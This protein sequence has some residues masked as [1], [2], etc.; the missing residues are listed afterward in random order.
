MI[1]FIYPFGRRFRELAPN[2]HTLG[3]VIHAR[4]G[5]SS[6]L[7]LAFSNLL[8]SIISLMVNLLRQGRWYRYCR[9]CRSTRAL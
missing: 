6:Q 7:I 5:A 8:G 9:L 3:E 1:L 4:H 2:A